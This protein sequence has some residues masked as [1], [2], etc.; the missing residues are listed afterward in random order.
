MSVDRSVSWKKAR[1]NKNGEYGDIKTKEKAVEIV[2]KTMS[3]YL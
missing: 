2:R 3:H 1:Q